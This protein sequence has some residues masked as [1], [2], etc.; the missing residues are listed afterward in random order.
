MSHKH[1]AVL[2]AIYHDPPPGNIQWREVESLLHHLGADVEAAHGARF[3]VR[4][5]QRELMLHHP[6]HS[7]EF[8]RPAIKA[9]RDFLASAGV[10]LSLYDEKAT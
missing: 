7:N 3:R 4:L 9:L 6:H 2:A 1:R 5:N 8:G 10:T